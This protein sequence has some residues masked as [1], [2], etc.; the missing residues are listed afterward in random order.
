[1]L[2]SSPD[3]A[4]KGRRSGSGEGFG[5]TVGNGPRSRLGSIRREAGEFEAAYHHCLQT[6]VEAT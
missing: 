5:P 4:L 3:R 1:M 6:V 2:A